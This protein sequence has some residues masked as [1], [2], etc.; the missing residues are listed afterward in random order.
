MFCLWC[1]NTLPLRLLAAR[2][3]SS[4]RPRLSLLLSLLKPSFPRNHITS[5]TSQLFSRRLQ[6]AGP[7]VSHGRPGERTLPLHPRPLPVS[8]SYVLYRLCLTHNVCVLNANEA[9]RLRERSRIF[10]IGLFLIIAKEMRCK[11]DEIVDFRKL[12][13]GG[14]NRICLITLRDGF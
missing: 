4:L 5:M 10:D 13:E 6:Y 8:L 7:Q 1:S 12:G 11:T 9:R 3:S 2:V 14:L